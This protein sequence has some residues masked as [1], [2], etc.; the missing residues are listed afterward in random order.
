MKS[1]QGNFEARGGRSQLRVMLKSGLL[2]RLEAAPG[3]ES[4]VERLLT[5]ILARVQR[6]AGTRVW[7]AVRLGPSSFAVVNAFPDATARNAHLAGEVAARLKEGVADL[8][9]SPL[10][11]EEFEVLA[12][13]LPR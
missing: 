7:M 9:A 3:K 8:L 13:K 12:S 5:G 11:L 4:D 6:E 2:M 10:H 1:V